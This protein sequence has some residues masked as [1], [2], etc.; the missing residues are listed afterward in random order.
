ML[1]M[2]NTHLSVDK[3]NFLVDQMFHTAGLQG[4]QSLHFEDFTQVV[5]GKMD[6]LWDV[7]LDWKGRHTFFSNSNYLELNVQLR[8]FWMKSLTKN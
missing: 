2:A 8:V 7:C 4:R 6:M 3:V 1:E 5:S